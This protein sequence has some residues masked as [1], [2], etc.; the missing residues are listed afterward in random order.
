MIKPS[1]ELPVILTEHIVDNGIKIAFATLNAGK[2]LNALSLPMIDLLLPQLKA[3]LA[4][5]AVAVIVFQGS[6][7]K[8]F[9]A[10][11]D[12]VSVYRDLITKHKNNARNTLNDD[13]ISACL[14][15]EFF[16]KEYQLDQ[17]IHNASKPIVM[18]ANGYVMGGGIGLVAGASHRIVTEKTVMAMPEITIGLYPDVGASW[19]LNQMPKGVGLFLGLTGMTFNGADAKRLKLADYVIDSEHIDVLV[20]ALFQLE[21]TMNE[22]DNH[23]RVSALLNSYSVQ[24]KVQNVGLIDN[25]IRKIQKVTAYDNVVDIYHAIVNEKTSSAWFNKAQQKLSQ[26]SPLSAHIIYQ[27]LKNCQTLT[28]AQCFEKEF[29]LSIRCCQFSEFTEGVRA[30]LVDKDKQPNWLYKN[31]ETVD[32]QQ[33]AWFFTSIEK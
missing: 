19:F 15:V 26:G 1:N 25:E 14:G 33:V 2:S 4:D 3:W 30:L 6:G 18:L 21:L 31:I 20:N 27:Q 7:D 29:N 12:V 22:G 32:N 23:Q 9:C 10:G 24:S 11:G 28:L 13:E 8:A 16:T 17:L 5:D